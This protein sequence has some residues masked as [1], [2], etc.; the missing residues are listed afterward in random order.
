[1]QDL[2]IMQNDIWGNLTKIHFPAGSVAAISK[3]KEGAHLSIFIAEM[4]L[5]AEDL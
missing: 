5:C 2:L 1:M 3:Y 4:G